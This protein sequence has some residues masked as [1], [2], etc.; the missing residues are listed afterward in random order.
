MVAEEM[1]L[2]TGTGIAVECRFASTSLPALILRGKH[3]V[4]DPESK[5]T[6]APSLTSSQYV[7]FVLSPL[8]V[9]HTTNN[10]IHKI[11]Q[12]YFQIQT[13]VNKWHKCSFRPELEK[14][15]N[16][17][18]RKRAGWLELDFNVINQLAGNKDNSVRSV[19]THKSVRSV[20]THKSVRSV[21]THK[22]SF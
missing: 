6:L 13:Q 12:T 1:S 9:C 16:M 14:S 3:P 11:L 4:N 17:R 21:H 18:V 5:Y 20:H 7:S 8:H 2:I 10:I 22:S 15:T 19:H